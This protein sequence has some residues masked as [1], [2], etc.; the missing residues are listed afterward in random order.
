LN[1][2]LYVITDRHATSDLPKTISAALSGV[3]RGGAMVQLR[4]KDLEGRAMLEL[5][6]ALREITRAVG[7]K[8]LINDR[9]DVAIAAGADG[10]HL[11]E[12]GLTITEARALLP[13]GS[14]IGA[15]THSAEDAAAR[16]D[17][18]AD[19]VTLGP[20]WDTPSKAALGMTP[21][22][23]APFAAL[24]GRPVFALGGIDGAARADEAR[25]AGAHGVAAIR[26]IVAADD[27]ARAAAALHG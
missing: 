4:E 12:R 14:L 25:R 18:G 20:V 26:G 6:R 5:A 22:G 24:R 16:L 10:V 23:V 7:A 3:P 17:E 9:V 27:P 11:P 13:A 1:S 8:L 19:L 21:I 15:S 2:R